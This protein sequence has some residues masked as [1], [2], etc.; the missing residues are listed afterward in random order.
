M[1]QFLE[2]VASLSLAVGLYPFSQLKNPFVRQ[3]QD[4]RLVVARKVDTVTTE[5]VEQL[6]RPLQMV[7][8]SLDT[9]HR[10]AIAVASRILWPFG[11]FEWHEFKGDRANHT[12]GIQIFPVSVGPVESSG[13][14]PFNAESA[15]F[16][17]PRRIETAKTPRYGAVSADGG[18]HPGHKSRH[19][20]RPKNLSN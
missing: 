12:P 6:G 5:V 1:Q 11:S 8:A 13:R 15:D 10:S 7:F 18:T 17:Q 19:G 16:A 4:E 2:S 20:S 14:H 9:V 3:E